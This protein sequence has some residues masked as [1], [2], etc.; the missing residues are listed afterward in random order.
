MIKE[1]IEVK[2]CSIDSSF[3]ERQRDQPSS[4]IEPIAL[5]ALKDSNWNEAST[6]YQ[7]TK[8]TTNTD[9]NRLK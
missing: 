7:G 1:V 2:E 9:L 5:I 8:K 6:T 3:N 4:S